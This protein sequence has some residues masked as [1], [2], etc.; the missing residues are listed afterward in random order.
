M[1]NY[2]LFTIVL[3]AFVSCKTRPDKIEQ[4]ETF[5]SDEFFFTNLT[6]DNFA[7]KVYD[8]ERYLSYET[9]GDIKNNTNES[10]SATNIFVK[11]RLVLENNSVLTDNQIISHPKLFNDIGGLVS[12]IWEPGKEKTVKIETIR[13]DS[14]F[15]KYSI[16]R[17]YIDYFIN[18]I[19]KSRKTEICKKFKTI[20]VVRKWE[21]EKGKLV[22]NK[23]I[24]N[25][26]QK[27]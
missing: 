9:I 3:L 16:K 1:R 26:K 27:I 11:I 19:N 12:G 18:A 25:S 7:I 4:Q 6:T 17:I 21:K 5:E 8:N 15:V 14:S 20:E 22:E 23:K 13:I 2:F 24:I 10:Y